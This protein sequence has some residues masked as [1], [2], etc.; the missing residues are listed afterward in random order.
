MR[1]RLPS[2]PARPLLHK[3][4]AAGLSAADP[5]HALLKHVALTRHSLR[6]GHRT[7]NLSRIDRIVLVGAGKASARMAQALETALGTRL[8]DGLV[9]VKTGHTVATKRITVLEAGH[10]IPDRAGLHATQRL[11]RLTQHLTPRDLLIM[12]LS[13]GAS[14]LLPAPVAGVTLAD[15]QRTTRLLLRSGA[16]INE[17]N[18]V[19]K[20]LSL[21]KG[22]G[23]ATSTRARIVTLLLSDVIGDDLG[24]IGSGPTAGDPSTFAD[25]VEMLQRFGSWHAVPDSVR[26]HLDRGRKGGAS[27]TLKPGSRRLRSVQHH[28]IGNNR[29]MLKAVARAAQQANLHTKF[30]SH[31]ITGDARVAAK[32]LTDLAKA[33]TEGHGLLKRPCCVVAGGETTVTVTG[34]GRGGRAQ[35][36]AASAAFEIAGL[37]NTWVVA[38]GSDG[39]DGPTDAAGAI[40]AGGTVAR[41]KKLGIDLRSSLDRHNTYPALKA[42]GCHIHTGPTGTNVNDLYLLLLL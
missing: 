26:R 10:P 27:E 25:A 40:V 1:L 34:R 31:S 2:S 19:R 18:V 23:L 20:H 29:I 32:Q 14:S 38:L 8:E 6:V 28:I 16:T 33:I 22:G 9:I 17:M 5:Y 41:A 37:P 39:T 12:L 13:G 15:K 4:I 21:I 11:L 24:S 30:V 36:F 35:E 7:Y 42:L 3:L